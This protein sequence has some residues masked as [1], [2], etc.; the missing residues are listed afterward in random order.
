[1]WNLA[2]SIEL[3]LSILTMVGRG[4]QVVDASQWCEPSSVSAIGHVIFLASVIEGTQT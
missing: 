4:S 2:S 3:L 1:M